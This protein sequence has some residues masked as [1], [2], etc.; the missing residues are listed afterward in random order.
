MGTS[1]SARDFELY[2]AKPY[3]DMLVLYTY[4]V[5]LCQAYWYQVWQYVV[6]LS[7]AFLQLPQP[8]IMTVWSFLSQMPDVLLKSL[9]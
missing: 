3:P 6:C 1:D 8:Y 5:K 4:L 7:S 9:Q 2:Q